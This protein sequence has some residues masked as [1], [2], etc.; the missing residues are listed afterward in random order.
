LWPKLLKANAVEAIAELR[1]EETFTPATVE[2]AKAFLLDPDAGRVEEKEITERVQLVTRE[3]DSQIFF[4]TRD[5][6]Q[7][8]AW[9]HRNYIK[10]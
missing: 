6:K 2:V 3:S 1:S 4:E 5:R 8:G 9:V 7:K 10:K